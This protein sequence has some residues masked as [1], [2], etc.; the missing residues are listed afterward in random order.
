MARSK[1]N[2]KWQFVEPVGNWQAVPTNLEGEVMSENPAFSAP[3]YAAVRQGA[4]EFAQALQAFPDSIRTVEEMGTLGNPTPHLV[5]DQIEYGHEP[6]RGY[7]A[8]LDRAAS[9][10]K[11][12]EMELERE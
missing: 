10:H 8:M 6:D 11:E 7:E 3:L 12:Q 5:T 4:K 2:V 1:A 9:I